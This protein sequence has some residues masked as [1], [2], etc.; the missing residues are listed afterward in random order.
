MLQNN[1]KTV[2]QWKMLTCTI[3]TSLGQDW[4][5]CYGTSA[6]SIHCTSAISSGPAA[7]KGFCSYICSASKPQRGIFLSCILLC[8]DVTW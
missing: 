6:H 2:S 8:L 5:G 4:A 7:G 1:F 3:T